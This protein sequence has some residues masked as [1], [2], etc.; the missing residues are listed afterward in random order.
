MAELLLVNPSKRRRKKARSRKGRMPPALAAYWAKHGRGGG[1]RR[2]PKHAKHASARRRKN[3]HYRHAHRARRRRNPSF[4]GLGSKFSLAALL[5]TAKQGLTG[6]V[7]AIAND[8]LMGQV[9]PL[10][11]MPSLLTSGI[12]ATLT[13][14][15]GALVVGVVGGMVW[16]GRGRDLADGAMTVAFHDAMKAQL[17]GILPASIPLGG[18]GEYLTFAPTVG[19]TPT[20]NP[21]LQEYISADAGNADYYGSQPQGVNSNGLGLYLA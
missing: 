1:G 5:T 17:T 3:P 20:G 14:A 2:R 9:M 6:G 4:R 21:Q 15:L 16:R 7:G 13:R 8:L 19:F 10:S 11:F 12:G 18:M